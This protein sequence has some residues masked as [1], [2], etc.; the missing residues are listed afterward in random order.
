M[1]DIRNFAALENPEDLV[2]DEFITRIQEQFHL[3]QDDLR[4]VGFD[5]VRG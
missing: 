5:D 3:S 1:T 2:S 4:E